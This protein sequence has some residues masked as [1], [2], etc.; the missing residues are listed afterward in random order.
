MDH[1]TAVTVSRT[2]LFCLHHTT[3]CKAL[4]S[5]RRR[6]AATI[7]NRPSSHRPFIPRCLFGITPDLPLRCNELKCFNNVHQRQQTTHQCNCSL[8]IETLRL[9]SI[10]MLFYLYTRSCFISYTV[11]KCRALTYNVIHLSQFVSSSLH[12]KSKLTDNSAQATQAWLQ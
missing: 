8:L 10:Y 3:V 12:C 11:T 7:P 9:L 5:W 6:R 4:S 2:R 1:T